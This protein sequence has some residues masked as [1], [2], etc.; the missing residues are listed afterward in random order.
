MTIRVEVVYALPGAQTVVPLALA[1]GACVQD[2]LDASGIFDRH[3]QINAP[4]C[5]V[6]IWGR[7]VDRSHPLREGDRVE[8]YRPLQADPKQARHTRAA[9]ERKRRG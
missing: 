8:V 6:G 4:G 1:A 7:V 3:P 9:Q 5:V 2:A